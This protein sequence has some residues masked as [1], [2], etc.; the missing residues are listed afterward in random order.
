MVISKS[1]EAQ[2]GERVYQGSQ[3][4]IFNKSAD[5][6]IPMDDQTVEFPTNSVMASRPVTCPKVGQEVTTYNHYALAA[7]YRHLT[8]KEDHL[9]RVEYFKR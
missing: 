3:R 7:C 1:D 9:V 4:L 6:T 5:T 8:I 2:F